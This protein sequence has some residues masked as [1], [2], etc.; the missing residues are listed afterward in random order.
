MLAGSYM[1]SL[2]GGAGG[3]AGPATSKADAMFDS[4]GWNVNFG[5][6]T[7]ESS[8]SKSNLTQYMQYALIAAGL[9]IAYRL[10]R[11]AKA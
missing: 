1:P 7:I 4:S 11:R 5:A 8:A 2:T 3:A 10:T 6:G 9:L